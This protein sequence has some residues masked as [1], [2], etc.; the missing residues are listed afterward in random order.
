MKIPRL[1]PGLVVALAFAAVIAGVIALRFLVGD[2][3]TPREVCEQ[4]CSAIGR[5]SRMVPVYPPAQTAGMRG[6]GPMQCDC[7]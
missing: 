3:P 4:K 6:Q 5:F 2:T 7:Y 1:P